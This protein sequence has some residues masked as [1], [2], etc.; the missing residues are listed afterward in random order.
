MSRPRFIRR[1]GRILRGI[2]WRRLTAAMA[3]F[4]V[5]AAVGA[6][7]AAHWIDLPQ[8]LDDADSTV[9]TY[10]DGRAAHVL[11]A[12]DD[13]W[14]LPTRLD[15]VDPAYVEALLALEDGRFYRHPGVD[16]IAVVRAAVDNLRAGTV[17]SGASTITMQLVRLLEPRPRTLRAKA[18]EALRALQLEM[19]MSKDEILE[20]YLRFVP[21]GGNLEGIEAATLSFWGRRPAGLSA[22]EIATLLA[23]PQNPEVRRPAPEHRDVLRTAR[24]GI[25][26]RLAD[27]EA[28]PLAARPDE[29]AAELDETKVPVEVR[30]LPRDIPH[31]VHWLKRHRPEAFERRET[32]RGEPAVR[33][34][35]TLD[36]PT[37]RRIA[38]IVDGQRRRLQATGASHAAVVVL[39]ADTGQVRGVVGNLD[40]DLSRPGSHLPAFASPRSTGSLLK[41]VVYAAALDEGIV[42]PSH[43]LLDVPMI[44]GDYRPENFDRQYR[45][46]VEAERALAMSLNI[47]FV[48]LLERLGVDEFVQ[49]MVRFELMGPVRRAGDG[50]LELVVGGMPASALEVAAMYAGVAR[51]GRPVMPEMYEGS[52]Q[53]QAPVADDVGPDDALLDLFM[54]GVDV[55]SGE[56]EDDG[57]RAVS[58]AAAWLTARALTRRPRPWAE[59]GPRRARDEGIVWKTGTSYAYR[60][61]WTAGFGSRYA[62]AVWTG[63]LAYGRHPQLVGADVA[64]PLFFEI[65]EAIDEPVPLRTRKPDDQLAKIEVCSRS[66]RRPGPH[67][68]QPSSVEA[69]ALSA[70]P[71]RCELHDEIDVDVATG[72]RLSD[73]CRPADVDE[74]ERRIVER[75]PG[76]AARYERARGRRAGNLPPLHPDCRSDTGAELTITS[77]RDE[78]TIVLDGD[79]PADRQKVRLEAY[80]SQGSNIHWFLDGRYLASAGPDEAVYW[81]PEPGDWTIAAADE[82]G[83][84]D[85]RNL[86]VQGE[87][88]SD[89]R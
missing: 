68:E 51:G 66:G 41:P 39:E 85:V 53:T 78:T 43:K 67:C 56:G 19:H 59:V 83:E 28:I 21:Y 37:Q 4:L 63:D 18:V 44:R 11:L 33:I 55:E 49:A 14:R 32:A 9:I 73:G 34:E 69:P 87:A 79:R 35:T 86:A 46:L 25:A 61:A 3:L 80:S 84:R 60:D 71:E 36:R 54:G 16:P 70:A 15:D 29:L 27:E 72:R 88:A 26:T 17:V 81:I 45:G 13:R 12:D 42:A 8:R 23:I 10:T 50:G 77:P 24:D 47:P 82:G 2:G 1:A 6:G 89:G 40:Y 75:L 38:R 76:P 20:A 7:V 58:E 57:L 22:A 74:V 5:A 64:A 62:V 48:R 31:L 52:P 30:G 65:V